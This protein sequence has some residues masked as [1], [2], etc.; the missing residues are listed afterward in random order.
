MNLNIVKMEDKKKSWSQSIE[1]DGKRKEV[2]VKE[3]ENGFVINITRS[4]EDS[5]GE[6]KWD[7]KVYISKTNPLERLKDNP[8]PEIDIKLLENALG[9]NGY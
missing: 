7:E 5:K 3:V 9:T 4:G 6:W 8:L 1:I 2:C